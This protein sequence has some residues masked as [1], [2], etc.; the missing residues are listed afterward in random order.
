MN[1][2][3]LIKY[4]QIIWIFCLVYFAIVSALLAAGFSPADFLGHLGIKIILLATVSQLIIMAFQ[5][6]KAGNRKF[7]ILSYILIL[8]I[9]GSSAAGS[10]LL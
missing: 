6:R 3:A 8:V 10:F 2:A 9:I 7:M 5:F 1:N 4:Q